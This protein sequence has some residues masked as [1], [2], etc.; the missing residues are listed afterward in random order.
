MLYYPE[1]PRYSNGFYQMKWFKLHCFLYIVMYLYVVFILFIQFSFIFLPL[2]LVGVHG[3]NS[4][5]RSA[6][7]L[8]PP[9]GCLD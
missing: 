5:R 2:F 1:Y 4:L 7:I 9:R 6:H 8:T 3:G